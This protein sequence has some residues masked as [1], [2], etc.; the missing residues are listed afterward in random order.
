MEKRDL[1]KFLRRIWRMER[2]IAILLGEV[3]E[4]VVAHL[5]SST[6]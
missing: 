3:E 6:T 5:Q 4:V 1:E 2:E